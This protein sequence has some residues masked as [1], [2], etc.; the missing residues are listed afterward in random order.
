MKK[1]EENDCKFKIVYKIEIV[2]VIVYTLYTTNC[3][4][5]GSQYTL[6]TTRYKLHTT[7]FT[8]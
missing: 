8:I 6:R 2:R 3:T 1:V 7:H 5:H 4:Q